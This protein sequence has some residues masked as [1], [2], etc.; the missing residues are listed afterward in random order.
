[1]AK[2]RGSRKK[3]R[4][5]VRTP[6]GRIVIHVRQAK[7]DKPKC[8]ICKN[9]INMAR[10]R[11]SEIKKL[12]KSAKRPNRPFSNICPSCMRE[13]IKERVRNLA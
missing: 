13:I 5:K 11:N 2:M 1:M 4:I 12:S 9:P 8:A 6:G 7:A 3:K 10:G